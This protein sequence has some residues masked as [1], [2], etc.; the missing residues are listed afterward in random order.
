MGVELSGG[1]LLFLAVRADAGMFSGGLV[2]GVGSS[3][4]FCLGCS[5]R[6]IADTYLEAVRVPTVLG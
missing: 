5:L 6:S 1:G 4:E 2:L 3:L